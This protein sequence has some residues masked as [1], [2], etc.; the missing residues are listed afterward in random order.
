MELAHAASLGRTD[1]VRHMVEEDPD[2]LCR[3]VEIVAL[4]G[5]AAVRESPLGA[6]KRRER[7][8]LADYLRKHG[9]TEQPSI[10]WR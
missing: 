10:V 1:E 8:E 3:P 7:T 2:I 4:I 6:A 5:G 9:A